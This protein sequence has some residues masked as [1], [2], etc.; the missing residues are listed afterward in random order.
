P[1]Y[2]VIG[3]KVRGGNLK[4]GSELQLEIADLE[5]ENLSLD[6]S[7]LIH[8]TDPMGHLENGILSYSHKC[9]RCHLKNVTV[10]NEGID[11]E[12]DH[13]FWKH[14]VKRKGALKI[15]LHGHS[16]FFAEN[17][18][19]TRDLTLEV[20]HG[21]RMHAEEKNGRVI[22]ITEPFESSRPF[23]NYSINSEKRIV[24]SRA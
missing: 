14:E 17:I 23:W 3:Q 4:E 8:A 2:S 6:G 16:E 18:T 15:V 22:F 13:L 9:G 12:E 21:M 20:P 1:L 19:I 24:L 7:L 11:W 10:K 5:M